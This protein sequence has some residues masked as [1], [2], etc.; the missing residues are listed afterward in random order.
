MLEED[1]ALPCVS[2]TSARTPAPPP[3][4]TGVRGHRVLGS[5]ET[6][7]KYPLKLVEKKRLAFQ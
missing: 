5:Q 4:V 3:V 6:P 7:R 1:S 2:G